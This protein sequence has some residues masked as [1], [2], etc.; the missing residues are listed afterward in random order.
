MEGIVKAYAC[1]HIKG[2]KIIMFGVHSFYE[3]ATAFQQ[4]DENVDYIDYDRIRTKDNDDVDNDAAAAADDDDDD[5]NDDDDA[6]NNELYYELYEQNTKKETNTNFSSQFH[7][8]LSFSA[9]AFKIC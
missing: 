2:Q 5:N 6:M 3:T 7:P 4:R 9:S 8:L 1:T